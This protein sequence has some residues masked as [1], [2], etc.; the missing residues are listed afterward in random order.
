ME[1][2]WLFHKMTLC[3]TYNIEI[4]ETYFCHL[5]KHIQKV[6]TVKYVHV[7]TPLKPK[8][9]IAKRQGVWIWTQTP[10]ASLF[11]YISIHVHIIKNDSSL[12]F[13]IQ[14]TQT[15][16]LQEQAN[17]QF[18]GGWE[19]S[20]LIQRLTVV[21][22]SFFF[23]TSI[24]N[25]FWYLLSSTVCVTDSGGSRE[26]VIYVSFVNSCG[27]GLR[28]LTLWVLFILWWWTMLGIVGACYQ[29]QSGKS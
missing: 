4:C 19:R 25:Y 28:P 7:A 8:W 10:H 29:E 2:F 17:T 13:I 5:T 22:F 9:Y 18:T 24:V 3:P 21:I 1:V 26:G 20:V 12:C 16:I 15:A 6:I 23:Y 14:R 11:Q 27:W